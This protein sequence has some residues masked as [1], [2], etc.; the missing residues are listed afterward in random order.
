MF[1]L[2][3]HII[4]GHARKKKQNA[5]TALLAVVLYSEM[6]SVFLLFYKLLRLGTEISGDFAD[7]GLT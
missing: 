2:K 6:K 1:L 3:I 4:I 7:T 5:K